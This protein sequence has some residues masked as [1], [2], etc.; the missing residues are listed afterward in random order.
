MKTIVA[1]AGAAVL[2][3]GSLNA[4]SPLV[5]AALEKPVLP[6]N[7]GLASYT[8]VFNE[9]EAADAAADD[10]WRKLK[11]RA[12]YDAY[13]AKMCERMAEAVGG[14]PER[15]PLNA[16]VVATVPR[17]GYRIE[18][19]LFESLPGVYVTGLLYVPES[20]EFKPPYPAFLVTC[21]HSGNGKGSDGYQR[22]CVQG[23][24]Q[25]MAAFI[26][27]P[28]AQGERMQVPSTANV[29][30]HNRFGVNA[31][32]LGRSTAQMRI[33]DGIRA[34]DYLQSRPDIRPDRIGYMGNSGGGTMTSLIMA[35]EPRVAAAAPSCY[36]SSIREV[37]DH[38]GPQDAEQCIF[39]QL[40]FGLNH[41]SFVLMQGQPVR[42][43]CCHNDFFTFMGSRQ[44]YR[45][46][47]ETAANLGLGTDRYGMTDVPGPHGWKESTRASSVQWMRRWLMDDASALPIDVDACRRLDIGFNIAKVDHGLDNPGYNVT[48]N[49]RISELPGFRSVYELLKDDLRKVREG[50]APARPQSETVCRVAG[51]RPL[52]E[53]KAT[54]V[55]VSRQQA[56]GLTVVKTAFQFEG[57][58]V[59][60]TVTFVPK[61]EAKA[62]VLLAGDAGRGAFTGRAEELLAQGTPVMVADLIGAGEIGA[63]KHRFYGAKNDDEEIA[64]LCYMLGKSLVGVRAEELMA[65]ARHLKG[66]F[67]RA[68][69]LEA[70][71][72]MAIPAAHARAVA[73]AL[74][75]GV[76]IADAPA[77]WTEVV[78]NSLQYPYANAVNGALLH[79]DWTDLLED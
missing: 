64:V 55:E 44:T 72:R 8:A 6:G 39:G 56:D 51:I 68:P 61:G 54:A 74:V 66:A 34:I 21:G 11:T 42:M 28:I 40:A 45:T 32:L 59:V 7:A 62:P 19:I 16:K 2:S 50:R 35:I 53:V 75:A 24:K 79:Y 41:A 4:A 46:V 48:P 13:R 58:L 26:Y 65:L 63:V 14:F 5:K 25:G 67:G 73:R 9:V 37:V 30:G 70:S 71:G 27:D 1:F 15:T 57:G 29:H 49:G 31:L 33:W 76:K 78:E 43:H 60:P 47:A 20:P 38:D 17:E 36:L 3:A 23:V 77:S 69:A 10:A 52:G 12:E 18:K 22:G